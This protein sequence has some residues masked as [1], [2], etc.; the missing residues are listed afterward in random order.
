MATLRAAHPGEFTAQ[1]ATFEVAVE[2][3]LDI[4]WQRTVVPGAFGATLRKGFEVLL[5]HSL[6]YCLSGMPSLA[7]IQT[8]NAEIWFTA[9]SDEQAKYEPQSQG[10]C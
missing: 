1:N 2:L 9:V 5:Y 8:G 3:P 10:R 7:W 4:E 6:K